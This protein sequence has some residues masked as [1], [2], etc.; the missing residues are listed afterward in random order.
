MSFLTIATELMEQIVSHMDYISAK[1]LDTAI[2]NDIRFWQNHVG[3][4]KAKTVCEDRLSVHQYIHRNFG[5]ARRL[6]TAMSKNYVYLSGGRSLEFFVP[7]TITKESDW[8]FYAPMDIAYIGD[9]MH[10]LEN[11]GVKWMNYEEDLIWKFKHYT[12]PFAIEKVK[13]MHVIENNQL[14]NAVV[15]CGL[16][17]STDIQLED[18]DFYSVVVCKGK[19]TINICDSNHMEYHDTP[20]FRVASGLLTYGSE[21]MLVQLMGESR[22]NGNSYISS[23]FMYHSSCVQSFISPYVSC[24]LYGKAACRGIAHGWRNNIGDVSQEDTPSYDPTA[25][26]I[27]TSNVPK[28]N[29]YKE[30]GF[31]YVDPDLQRLDA[32]VRRPTDG[33]SIWI[34]HD[35]DIGAP[36]DVRL[37][38]QRS[39]ANMMWYQNPYG[40]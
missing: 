30:R 24:H 10:E 25:S 21:T 18:S 9:F 38:Y 40:F 7:G 22:P 11:I 2:S 8:D 20:S 26:V 39:Y 27:D 35:Y 34:E 12:E 6:F 16:D 1:N 32:R 36:D 5:N 29:K 31:T 17:I 13:L 33:Q 14:A 4:V 3:H 28:W 23:P 19:V 37:M 15:A